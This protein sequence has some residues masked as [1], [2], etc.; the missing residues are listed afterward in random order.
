MIKL[1]ITA[2]LLVV[3]SGNI[4]AQS[5]DEGK[6]FLYYERNNSA[7]DVFT[8]L[9]NANPNNIEAVY[10]LGQTYLSMED[11]AAAKALYQKTMQANPNAPLLIVGVGHIELLENKTNDARNRFETAISLTKGKDAN[12][13]NAIGKANVD[14]K[15][16]DATYAIEKLK[17]AAERDKKNA[18]IL[19][20]LGDAYR[21]I[22]DGA[23]AQISYQ[24][25]LALNP[26]NA[27]AN[28][29]IGRLYQTQGTS[30]EQYYM[31][32]YN[33]AIAQDPNFAPVYV[34]LYDYYYRR[35]VNKS[36]DY[37][38]KYISVADPDP[39]NC[40]Y[41]ASIL[42]ASQ[43]YK[44]SIA[45]SDEC[46]TAGGNNPYPNLF[47]LKAY[48]YDKLG[49]STNARTFFE[50]YF[51]KQN[52]EK[53]GPNDYATYARILLKFPG[54]DSIAAGYAEKAVSLDTLESN[55]IDYISSIAAN[56]AA[57]KNYKEA[58][59]WYAK[60]LNIKKNFGKVD[61]HNAAYN[62]Y[63]AGN[64]A[65][66]DSI[67][68]IYTQKYPDEIYGYK[69]R[70]R[71]NEGID[72]TRTQGLAN[73]YYEKVIALAE[74][75]TA[76]DK[77]KSDLIAAY[78]YMVAYYYNIKND[79][80]TALSYTD[81]ILAVDPANAAAQQNKTA[82]QAASVKQKTKTET[83]EKGTETKVKTKPK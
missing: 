55:K 37:L 25:A 56:Y 69:W 60:V 49:D 30:Q 12:V 26:K 23:N 7:K 29:M 6:R 59:K 2:L 9:V 65:A 21:K 51:Q 78:N 24:S 45:K 33:D 35:D 39:K 40:Y 70:A 66:A 32:Y 62:N 79:K 47:G 42:Y 82:L 54:N 43:L 83:K 44:E 14:A 64:Y 28:F 15:A 11:T 75:D 3:I 67:Y 52:P 31:K 58:G 50:S 1:K 61:L 71:A 13:L 53:L 10:W 72:S 18:D 41:Q 4:M 5:L 81:K 76:K 80:E 63:L 36:R 57:A 8:K 34:W 16:G 38:A 27:R 22:T 73:P 19:M 46:I 17:L 77:V 48:A 74:A 68:G 20:N